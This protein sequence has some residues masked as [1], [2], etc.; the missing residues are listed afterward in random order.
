VRVRKPLRRTH[1]RHL[2]LSRSLRVT[3][4]RAAIERRRDCDSCGKSAL[5]WLGATSVCRPP[6]GRARLALGHGGPLE[7]E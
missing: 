6:R 2:R 1:R 3:C 5:S 4:G 7:D